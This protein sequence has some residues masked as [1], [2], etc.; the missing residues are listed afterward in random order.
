MIRNSDW[1]FADGDNAPVG[2]FS[3]MDIPGIVPNTTKGSFWVWDASMLGNQNFGAHSGTKYLFAL[4]RYDGGQTDDW[5]ISPEL[6]G[7]A[8][9]ISFFARSYSSRYQEKITVYYSTGGKEMSDFIPVDGSTV[10]PL[11]N[12]WTEYTAA[13][14]EGAKYFAIRSYAENSYMLMVDDVTYEAAPV[15]DLGLKGYNIYRDGNLVTGQPVAGTTY[16]DTDVSEGEQYTYAVTAVYDDRGESGPS[17]EF[18]IKYIPLSVGLTPADGISVV[19]GEGLI[20]VRGAEGL[21]LSV[22]ATDGRLLFDGTG[23]AETR[24]AAGRGVYV[25]TAG[26][27]ATKIIVK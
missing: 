13:L 10:D 21:G 6:S 8:Q 23:K 20:V 22:A 19:S 2:G 15:S 3:G 25:V 18:V 5:A 17:N 26:G 16:V 1:T 9:T 11:P 7:N 27:K 14:P 24:I 12:K 4:F